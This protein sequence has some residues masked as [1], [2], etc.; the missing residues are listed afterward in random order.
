MAV[1]IK[2][3]YSPD[4]FL[5]DVQVLLSQL[6]SEKFDAI[7]GL[8]R[9]GL[10]LGTILANNL[11]IQE[12]HT[13]QLKSYEGVVQREMK[14]ICEPHW[15]LLRNKKI[16]VVDDLIDNGTSIL[17]LKELLQKNQIKNYKIVV[18]IDKQKNPNIKPDYCAR[19]AKE[20][21]VFFWERGYL[22]E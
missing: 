16:L 11:E 6:R 19:I 3:Y 4:L 17:F 9:G 22:N 2:L 18:L 20:W 8:A 1:N 7:L 14:L 15:D 13:I 10:V 12:Y 21:I 5:A